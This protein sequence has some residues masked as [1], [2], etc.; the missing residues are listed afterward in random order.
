MELTE[1][2]V[3]L[4]VACQEERLTSAGHLLSLQPDKFLSPSMTE[5][6]SKTYKRYWKKMMPYIQV[7][8]FSSLSMNQSQ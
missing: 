6:C 4:L 2:H 8:S 7:A 1:S 5:D 3:R